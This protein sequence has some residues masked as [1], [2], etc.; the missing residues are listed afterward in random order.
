[1]NCIKMQIL[2]ILLILIYLTVHYQAKAEIIGKIEAHVGNKIITS[3]DV[4]N[5]DT[6]IYKQIISIEDE[7]TRKAQ[8]EQYREQALAFL[9]EATIMEIAA[10]KDGVRVTDEEVDK[11]ISEIITANDVT[12]SQFEELI[13][14]DGL[15]MAQ[16]RYQIKS[17]II[18]AR[19]RGQIF[20]PQV[21]ITESDIKNAI[22]E[23]G[24]AYGLKDRYKIKI[25][26]AQSKS[27]INKI[28]KAIKQG[29]NFED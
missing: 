2:S 4:E 18:Q 23:K 5:L 25:I 15:S 27:E 10:E 26:T 3:Y 22:D 16:Y 13:Q 8:L 17:Q 12:E 9:I 11:A 24:E 28:I 21:V 20:M 29:A 19:I 6:N 14:K 1:M 7:T